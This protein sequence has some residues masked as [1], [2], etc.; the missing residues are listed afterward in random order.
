[1][2]DPVSSGSPGTVRDVFPALKPRVKELHMGKALRGLVLAVLA[3]TALTSIASAA[4]AEEIAV[5]PAGEI[6]QTGR[7]SIEFE[8]FEITCSV[9]IPGTLAASFPLSR[10]AVMGSLEP[11]VQGECSGGAISFRFLREATELNYWE[12]LHFSGELIDGIL[13]EHAIGFLISNGFFAC[14][15]AGRL[16]AL[17]EVEGG[18]FRHA[19]I[20]RG[21]GIGLAQQL[22]GLLSCPSTM[23]AS[24]GLEL[25]SNHAASLI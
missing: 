21:N 4:G 7:L 6:T 17:F 25:E 2:R 22:S 16:K 9:T 5:E 15:Y 10:G 24:G 8:G 3:A 18:I 20:L 11:I 19:T 23:T 1:V 12:V 13:Y 14:L